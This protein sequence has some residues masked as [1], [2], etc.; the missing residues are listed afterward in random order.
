MKEITEVIVLQ[1]ILFESLCYF[2]DFCK[3]YDL[4]YFL[5]NGT[6]L[7]AAKYGKF[8]PWDDDVD[9][10][11]PRENYN[12][13]VRLTQINNEKFRLLCAEQ[14]PLWRMPYAKLSRE[15]T[16][17]QEGE[18]NFGAPFGLSVDIFPIDHWHPF[19]PFAL[20]QAWRAEF[21]KRYLVVSIGGDFVTRKSGIKKMILRSI[22]RRGKKLGYQRVLAKMKA[23][24][25]KSVKY[26]KKYVGCIAWTCHYTK[27]VLNADVFEKSVP[28]TFCQ[29]EFPAPVGYEHYLDSLYGA[30]RSELPPEDQHSNHDIKVWWKND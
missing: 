17:I 18:Y 2:D 7:G 3:K 25:D 12:K 30:W 9:I 4:K 21:L 1:N 8:I 24:T 6:L 15:D 14:E 16:V 11:M 22:W 5:A 20:L 13:L 29:R 26:R 23:R 28:L 19:R 10:L 27:E